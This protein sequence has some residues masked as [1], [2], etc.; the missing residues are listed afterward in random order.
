MRVIKKPKFKRYARYV[1]KVKDAWRRPRGKSNKLR[2]HFKSRGFLVS[3]GYGTPKRLRGLHPCGLREVL[4]NNADELVKV[5]PSIN[6]VRISSRVGKK[7]RIDI[8]KKAE[9]KK[10]KI[11][12]PKKV[13]LKKKVVKEKKE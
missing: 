2:R 7:K 9:E 12:N 8:Q 3:P 11:L 6:C 1:K 4:I 13:E 10:I 5:D